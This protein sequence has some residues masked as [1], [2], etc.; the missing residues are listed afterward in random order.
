MQRGQIVTEFLAEAA[1]AT[2]GTFIHNNNDLNGSLLALSNEPEVSY[3]LG[4]SPHDP[5]D[6]KYHKL[7]VTAAGRAGSQVTARTGYLSEARTQQ[8]ETA[9]HHIDRVVASAELIDQIPAKLKVNSTTGKDGRFRLQ[10][11]ITLDAKLLP[12]ADRDGA[13]IQELTFVTVV[14]DAA[15]NFVE[16]KQAVMD[17]TLTAPR[18]AG[19][20]EKGIKA[21]TQFLVPAGSYRVREVI[22]E[23]VHNRF[24]ASNSSV[25]IH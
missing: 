25:E 14:Q 9:Q 18:R 23:A 22:R 15:G 19:L 12:F 7:K 2:G 5:P 13:S 11:D 1:A 10:V 8:P 21:S 6:G 24:F 3:L 16:G 17:M 20:E 4:F